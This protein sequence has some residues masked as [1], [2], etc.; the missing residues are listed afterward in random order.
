MREGWRLGAVG[1]VFIAMFTVLGARLWFVQVAAAPDYERQ[2][3]SLVVA[4]RTL[5]APRGS[6]MDRSGTTIVASKFAPGIV[7]DRIMIPADIEDSIVQQLSGLMG[8]PAVSIWA[9]F[10]QAGSANVVHLGT[11]SIDVAYYVWEH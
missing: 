8:V 2:A 11:V 5:P 3:E 1:L 6:I 4:F 7:V 10:D 9:A